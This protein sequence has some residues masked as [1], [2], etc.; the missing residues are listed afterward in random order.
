[1]KQKIREELH[2]AAKFQNKIEQKLERLQKV[3]YQCIKAELKE[4]YEKKICNVR[5]KVHRQALRD[6][7]LLLI[8]Q[9]AGQIGAKKSSTPKAASDMNS[10]FAQ[11]GRNQK[12]RYGGDASDKNKTF[13]SEKTSDRF[14]E[15]YLQSAQKAIEMMRS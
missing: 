4:E 6:P 14:Y 15:F 11:L 10:T 13:A 7:Q 8:H 9:I 2:G 1:V 12:Q 3:Q 5:S